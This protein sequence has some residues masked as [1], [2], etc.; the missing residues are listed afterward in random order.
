MSKN[1]E[2][3]RHAHRLREGS[4]RT[5][6]EP[7]RVYSRRAGEGRARW[8]DPQ[9]L[10]PALRVLAR[11]WPWVL[12]FAVL[13]P[14]LV[15]AVVF[16]MA[17]V[18]EP[19]ARIELNSGQQLFLPLGGEARLSTAQYAETQRKNLQSG[20]LQL[21]VIRKLGLDKNKEWL[22]TVPNG[23]QARADA[24]SNGGVLSP[25]EYAALELFGSSLR[26]N[27]ENSSWLIDVSFAA[28]DPKLSALVTNT[29][30]ETFIERDYRN[31]ANAVRESTKWLSQQLDDIRQRMNDSKKALT[32]FQT[33]SGITP[34]S[35]SRSSFDERA[36]ELNRQLTLARVER[37]QLEALLSTDKRNAYSPAQVSVDPNVQ[38]ISKKL[39]ALRAEQK[40]TLVIYGENHPKAKQLQAEI[41]E[42]QSEFALQEK[43]VLA[44]LNNSFRAAHTREK[45][46]DAEV[47]NA[48][49]QMGLAEQYDSLRKESQANEEL[50][51]SLFAKVKETAILGEATPSNIR[52]V[53][54][55]QVLDRPTRPRRK[56]DIAA[57]M[58]AGIF[59]G[60]LLAFIRESVNTRLRS[61]D[62]VR[63]W[64]E[65]VSVSLVPLV[66]QR[67]L[68]FRPKHDEHI[69]RQPFVL[70]RP[71]SPEAEALRGLVTSVA[72]WY[73]GCASRVLLVASS[74]AG[75]GKT[76]IAGNLAIA[77]ARSGKTCLVD[78]DLRN[79]VL[80]SVF[81]VH[82]ERGL[83]ALFSGDCELDHALIALDEVPNL[84]LLPGGR[85]DARSSEFTTSK[86]LRSLLETLRDRFQY[87]IVDSPPLL[88]YADSRVIAPLVDG[89][90]LVAR[91]GATTREALQRSLEIL[92]SVR[93][94]P[95]LD[96]V[97]NAVPHRSL[98]YGYSYK[99]A[100]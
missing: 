90:V 81:Q 56:L 42:L 99:Y 44:A 47:K 70:E 27:Q 58:V 4:Q 24:P 75:E 85:V 29:V 54:H 80:A 79:P 36:A 59:G 78:A 41:D 40:Q 93:A 74:H 1:L 38:E 87:V 18:Y 19:S 30:V 100:S 72:S 17:P 10:L 35:E 5:L 64:M 69:S 66:R 83:A 6:V 46:L 20:E 77:L 14:A 62:D 89:I 76:T 39:G 15:G 23:S 68:N 86:K 43:R 55:A 25:A 82:Q 8:E 91:A 71:N 63:E 57:G 97:L 65:T 84:T 9:L 2:L 33:T 95:V 37:I 52:W 73:P 16:T 53:D 98:G 96:V 3:L 13:V 61:V 45:L 11:H 88:P 7:R 28:H 94:A 67:A 60:I 26:V 31:R 34:V 49:K 12:G 50:Y 21:E 51:K 48:T 32:D 22:G 92:N